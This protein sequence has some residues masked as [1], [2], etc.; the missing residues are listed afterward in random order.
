M[1]PG[2]LK[3]LFKRTVPAKFHIFFISASVLLDQN[4]TALI[5]GSHTKTSACALSKVIGI[6][7]IRLHGESSPF[8]QCE[9]AIQ[10]SA[11]YRDYAHATLDII[12]KFG[13]KNIAL[14][15]DGKTYITKFVNFEI[16]STSCHH[17][18]LKSQST[19]RTYTK[20]TYIE[21]CINTSV[22]IT[23]L[24]ICLIRSLDWSWIFPNHITKIKD[25]C[26]H[27]SAYWAWREWRSVITTTNSNGASWKPSRRSY[28]TIRPQRKDW[29]VATTSNISA[30]TYTISFAF[31]K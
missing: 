5:E 7:L 17:R 14:V 20:D 13:W 31:A 15:I 6:P 4:F 28:C 19:P 16:K 10:M 9:E 23:S 22:T 12:N 26:E 1:L 18:V 30:Y 27:N 8:D 29:A 2:S 11:G 21:N 24:C 3:G 25:D